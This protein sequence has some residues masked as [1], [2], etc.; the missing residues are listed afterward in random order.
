MTLLRLGER[1]AC[2]L[3]MGYCTMCFLCIFF[4]FVGGSWLALDT[5]TGRALTEVLQVHLVQFRDD[6]L[7]FALTYGS[8]VQNTQS[9]VHVQ[10][11]NP[12]A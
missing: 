1:G 3:F 7:L 4:A 9:F 5:Q 2:V 6:F 11:S 12:N 8:P 10:A